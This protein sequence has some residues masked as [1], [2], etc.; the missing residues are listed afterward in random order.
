MKI[1]LHI[2]LNCYKINKEH[3]L[4]QVDK[5]DAQNMHIFM[6]SKMLDLKKYQINNQNLFSDKA[7]KL[8]RIQQ[9]IFQ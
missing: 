2:E 4:L 3:V 5:V 8:V 1:K 7:Y 9:P 6:I